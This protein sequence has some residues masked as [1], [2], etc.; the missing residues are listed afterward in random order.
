MPRTP[1]FVSDSLFLAA[2]VA[3]SVAGYI[4]GLGFYSD[5]WDF[6]SILT[7]ADDASLIGL[8]R[9]PWGHQPQPRHAPD[10]DRLPGG[11]VPAL[12]PRTP[13]LHLVNAVVLLA[14]AV[15]AHAVLRQARLPR[16]LAVAI[17]AVYVLLPNYAT[18]RFWFAR[19]ATP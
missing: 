16:L 6:L 17:P 5:D 18:N 11:A 7:H 3:L 10:A 15:L 8:V 14:V 1:A 12:R 9:A 2:L 13:R 4:G 19:S